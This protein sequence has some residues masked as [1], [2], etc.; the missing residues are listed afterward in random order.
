MTG[1]SVCA[2]LVAASSIILPACEMGQGVGAGDITTSS[3]EAET[4]PT[5]PPPPSYV[6]LPGERRIRVEMAVDDESRARGLM[7]RPALPR[8]EGML[9]VFARSGD[10]PF[11]MKN[12]II[13]LDMI[14][15]NEEQRVASIHHN[16]PPCRVDPCPSYDPGAPSRYVLELG[17]GEVVFYGL[18]VGDAV[19]FENVDRALAR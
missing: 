13:P 12:T 5:P 19:S 1:K 10:Y 3:T 14:W 9:F 8:G 11:W 18:K 15:I 4:T 6:V 7:Q 17:A 2:L 16:V